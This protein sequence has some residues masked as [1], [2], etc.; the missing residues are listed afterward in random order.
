MKA[1]CQGERRGG[2]DVDEVG[3]RERRLVEAELESRDGAFTTDMS[4]LEN[5]DIARNFFY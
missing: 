2:G 3:K 5:R 1:R 4:G